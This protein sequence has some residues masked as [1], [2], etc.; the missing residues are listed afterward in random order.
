MPDK[1]SDARLV[2]ILTSHER[3][4]REAGEVW[5]SE[6]EIHAMA[7]ELMEARKELKY[8]RDNNRHTTDEYD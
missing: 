1:P 4:A 8:Y 3:H 2:E 6:R 7:A 5:V